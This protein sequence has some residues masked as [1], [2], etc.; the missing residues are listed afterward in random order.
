MK[1]IKEHP[2]GRTLV[3]PRALR[4]LGCRGGL[5]GAAPPDVPKLIP[6]RILALCWAP[7]WCHV[8]PICSLVSSL[9]I[10]ARHAVPAVSRWIVSARPQPLLVRA[11]V[12]VAK[13]LPS[14]CGI[15]TRHHKRE[16][17]KGKWGSTALS[18]RWGGGPRTKCCL[19]ITAE[20]QGYCGSF[21]YIFQV[22]EKI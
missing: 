1:S 21:G 14:L 17:T 6:S 8:L 15:L 2:G 11:G 12:I 13:L 16:P 19:R 22:F 9:R 5:G 3:H 18:G 10:T 7:I 4:P 20:P